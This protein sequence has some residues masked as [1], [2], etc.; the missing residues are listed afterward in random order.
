MNQ[1][2]LAQVKVTAVVESPTNPRT[3]YDKASIT[4]LAAT[5]KSVGVLQPMYDRKNATAGVLPLGSS[6][7][8][9]VRHLASQLVIQKFEDRWD[10]DS[11]IKHAKVLGV[12]V[13]KVVDQVAPKPKPEKPAKAAKAKGN[14]AAP[15]A[16]GKKAKAKKA[17]AKPKGK[18]TVADDI[19]AYDDAGAEFAEAMDGAEA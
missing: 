13:N 9:L 16:K 4:E 15:P 11:L 6:P 10:R 2:T 3:H 5:M 12:D 14:G 8:D 1:S 19:D 18:R 7:E 17:A